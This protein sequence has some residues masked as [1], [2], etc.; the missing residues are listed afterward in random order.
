MKTFY[1]I[2]LVLLLIAIISIVPPSASGL[3]SR[4][5]DPIA[6]EN[7][8]KCLTRTPEV[9]DI[10]RDLEGNVIVG[11]LRDMRLFSP[12]SL[13]CIQEQ[14]REYADEEAKVLLLSEY[15]E[16]SQ[17]VLERLCTDYPKRNYLPL[18]LSV[19][20][21]WFTQYPEQGVVLSILTSQLLES[22]RQ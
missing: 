3:G 20:R 17:R 2:I 13:V 8:N 11:W 21:S 14:I 19:C 18:S 4:N 1:S 9:I 6:V 5:S 15:T 7:L 10:Q 16:Q 22:M 12:E